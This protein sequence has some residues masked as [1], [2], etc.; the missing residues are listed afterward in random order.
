MTNEEIAHLCRR[1]E[2]VDK[3]FGQNSYS[4]DMTPLKQDFDIKSLGVPN[5]YLELMDEMNDMLRKSR[6]LF[7]HTRKDIRQ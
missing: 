3:N 7:L 5:Y 1:I 6:V 4:G 2:D